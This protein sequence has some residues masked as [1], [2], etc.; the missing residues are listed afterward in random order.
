MKKTEVLNENNGKLDYKKIEIK[1]QGF[2][3][4]ETVCII[5]LDS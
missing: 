4:T 5:A 1:L 3:R 2:Y